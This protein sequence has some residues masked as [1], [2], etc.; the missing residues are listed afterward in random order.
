M[1]PPAKG[2][3]QDFIRMHSISENTLAVRCAYSL[4]DDLNGNELQP[5]ALSGTYVQYRRRRLLLKSRAP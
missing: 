3:L 5:A 1:V 4:D 2:V